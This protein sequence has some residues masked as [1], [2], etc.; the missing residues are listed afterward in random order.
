[1]LDIPRCLPFYSEAYQF[2]NTYNKPGWI[3][4]R[5]A[6]DIFHLD[7]FCLKPWTYLTAQELKTEPV[8][9]K[10]ALYSSGGYV[11]NIGYNLR[12]ALGVL[13]NLKE[14]RWIDDKTA[15]VLIEFTVFQPS[16]NLF[17]VLNYL[18]ERYPTGDIFT[19][20]R[21]KT[22]T[23][24]LPQGSKADQLFYQACQ[25]VITLVIVVL[26]VNEVAKALRRPRTYFTRLWSWVDIMLISF[27]FSAISL[28][29]HKDKYTREYVENVRTNPFDNHSVDQIVLYSEIED[30]LLACVMLFITI[31]SLWIIR[32]N[33]HILRTQNTLRDSFC[34]LCSFMVVFSVIIFAFASFGCIAFGSSVVEYSSLIDA[35]LSLLQM[36]IGG[37]SSYY[38]LK[39]AS[40]SF[41]GPVFLFV[42]LITAVVLLLNVFIAIL[43]NYYM[44]AR[45]QTTKDMDRIEYSEIL[46]YAWESVKA[47][48]CYLYN[49]HE[50]FRES[51]KQ[52]KQSHGRDS[53]KR[54]EIDGSAPRL[55]SM[56]SLEDIQVPR[57]TL[58]HA[59]KI[60]SEVEKHVS[61]LFNDAV[62]E[63]S[64]ES[65]IDHYSGTSSS[66]SEPDLNDE[67]ERFLEGHLLHS[68]QPSIPSFRCHAHFDQVDK[69]SLESYV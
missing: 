1:M 57:L 9:G 59:D 44:A 52:I 13:N 40:E 37:K 35:I 18:Y 46:I 3:P 31:K 11:A 61:K 41:L 25:V 67:C 51:F 60:I 27:A 69:H 43:D 8:R 64:V 42:Y 34:S 50:F 7:S 48:M 58:K 12:S 16:T 63:G 19:T 32:L 2:K 62:E 21:V 4:V 29:F 26:A 23:V 56:E 53:L 47:L 10:M 39:V 68:P 28:M 66:D 5:N 36:L 65:D 45:E 49:F 24:Y 33:T 17:S 38:Q 14:D 30:N 20:A 54:N 15:A 6:S 22:I 55:A